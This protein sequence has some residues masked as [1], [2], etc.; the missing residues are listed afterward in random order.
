[1]SYTMFGFDKNIEVSNVKPCQYLD[2]WPSKEPQTEK[3]VGL[4]Q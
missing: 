3:K 1:M 4:T 2:R